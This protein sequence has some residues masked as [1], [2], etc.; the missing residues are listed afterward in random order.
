MQ[1]PTILNSVFE[2]CTVDTEGNVDSSDDDQGMG[3]GALYYGS[4]N[5]NILI[6]DSIFQNCQTKQSSGGAIRFFE[7]NEF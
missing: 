7:N 4:N 5:S 3:G 1:G 6:V 2:D